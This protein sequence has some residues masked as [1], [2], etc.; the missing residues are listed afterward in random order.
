MCILICMQCAL[1]S[2]LSKLLLLGRKLWDNGSSER[3]AGQRQ[4]S[5][6]L[7]KSAVVQ[8]V[9]DVKKAEQSYC[10]IRLLSIMHKLFHQMFSWK[11][12]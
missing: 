2:L 6:R 8:A 11:I 7:V 12:S 10:S 5:S 1:P 3:K 4:Y 9:T